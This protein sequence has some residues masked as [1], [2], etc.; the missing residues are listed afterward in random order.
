M[1]L[2]QRD[3]IPFNDFLVAKYIVDT[4]AYNMYDE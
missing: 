2:N 1:F 3:S 4:R